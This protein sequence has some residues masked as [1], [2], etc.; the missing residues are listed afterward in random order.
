MPAGDPSPFTVDQR[1]GIERAVADAERTCGYAFSVW[2]GATEHDPRDH[3][4][5]LHAE[6]PDPER[7]VLVA[8]DPT[9]RALEVVTG[10]QVRRDLDDASAGLAALAMQTSFAAGDLANGIVRGVF[11]LAEHARP[12]V[13]LHTDQ[14]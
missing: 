14:A 10:K 1:R 8:V 7:S 11:Q 2:V 6:L 5:R 9:V 12:P 4:I 13:L 3:A